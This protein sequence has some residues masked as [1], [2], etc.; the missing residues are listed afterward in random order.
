MKTIWAFP[1][2]LCMATLAVGGCGRS[3]GTRVDPV[4]VTTENGSVFPASLAGRWKASEHGWEFVIGPDGRIAS[5]ILSQGRVQVLPGQTTTVAT[6]TGEPAVF[7]PGPWA[8]HYEPATRL[9]TVKI[10]MDHVRV[11]MGVNLVEGSSTDIFSG[12][13]SPAGDTWQVQ[14]TAFTQYTAR[15]ADGNSVDLSTD[16]TY[17]ETMSLVFTKT[18]D[19]PQ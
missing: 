5:A 3:A 8:V 18:T 10:T 12:F 1:A 16:K 14:W 2:I 11:P 4:Q 13:V 9:L 7:T 15:L 6:K 17:G 19:T